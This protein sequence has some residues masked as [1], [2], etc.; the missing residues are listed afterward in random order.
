MWIKFLIV[1]VFPDRCQFPVLTI[2]VVLILV[3]NC[4]DAFIFAPCIS[5]K[6][7]NFHRFVASI[8]KATNFEVT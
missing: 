5:P 7:L 6:L 4:V 8:L 1:A 2:L 3:A